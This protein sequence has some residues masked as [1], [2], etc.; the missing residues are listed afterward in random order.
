MLLMLALECKYLLV[1]E[2]SDESVA[3]RPDPALMDLEKNDDVGPPDEEV[4][5]HIGCP[6]PGIGCCGD[7]MPRPGILCWNGPRARPGIFCG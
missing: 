2:P 5:V 4:K 7:P 6:M 3:L 1:F